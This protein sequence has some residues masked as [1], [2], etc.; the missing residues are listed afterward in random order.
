MEIRS[1]YWREMAS[2]VAQ[3]AMPKAGPRAPAMA[4]AMALPSGWRKEMRLALA[5]GRPPVPGLVPG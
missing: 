3:L 5:W 2:R 1:A 4:A